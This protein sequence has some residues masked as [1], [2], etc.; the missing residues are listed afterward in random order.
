MGIV[1]DRV[2]RAGIRSIVLVGALVWCVPSQA[3]LPWDEYHR[4]VE[5]WRTVAPLK[6]DE[7]FGDQVDLYS[8]ALSFS[9]TDV[10]VPGD[11]PPISVA[12]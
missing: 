4:L 12:H 11:V 2:R 3:K 8:G 5:K 1:T 6:S 7:V 10:S 9:A